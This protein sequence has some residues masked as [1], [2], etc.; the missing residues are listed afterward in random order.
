MGEA[1][2]EVQAQAHVAYYRERVKL[3]L[4]VWDEQT[5][6]GINTPS[7]E[8]TLKREYDRDDFL[9][10]SYP[11]TMIKENRMPSEWFD[12]VA[13]VREINSFCLKIYNI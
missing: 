13:E 3:M 7:I 12:I 4:D 8:R 10:I 1:Y 5:I 11:E 9:H 2:G 6:C